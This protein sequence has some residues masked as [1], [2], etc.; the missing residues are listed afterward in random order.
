MELEMIKQQHLPQMQ[1]QRQPQQQSGHPGL[2]SDPGAGS[3]MSSVAS[4]FSSLNFG[5]KPATS[6]L[7]PPDDVY[8]KQ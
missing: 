5:N 4:D 1:Q 6:S 8:D 2:P 7:P 3:A